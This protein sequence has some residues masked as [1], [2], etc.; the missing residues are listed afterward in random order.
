MLI[1]ANKPSPDSPLGLTVGDIINDSNGFT[2]KVTKIKDGSIFK[3]SGL[4]VGMKIERINGDTFQSSKEG[5]GLI[6]EA[7]NVLKLF[8]YTKP[9]IGTVYCICHSKDETMNH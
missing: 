1:Y 5:L 7:M 9:S 8:V 6:K 2:L 3:S 4:V